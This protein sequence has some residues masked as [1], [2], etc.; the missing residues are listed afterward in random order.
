MRSKWNAAGSRLVW[1]TFVIFLFIAISAGAMPLGTDG[2]SVDTSASKALLSGGSSDRDT[3]NNVAFKAAVMPDLT[4]GTFYATA[5]GPTT[6][7][8]TARIANAGTIPSEICD[9]A[10][11]IG[12]PTGSVLD[13]QTV[14]SLS[15]GGSHDLLFHWDT[16][17]GTYADA[18]EKAYVMVDVD[19]DVKESNES[20]NSTF[21]LAQVG[22]EGTATPSPTPTQTFTVT[23]TPTPTVPPTPYFITNMESVPVFENDSAHMHFWLSGEPQADV[24]VAVEKLSGDENLVLTEGAAITIPK[25]EWATQRRVSIQAQDD[26]DETEGTATFQIREDTSTNGLDA[27]QFTAR[28][29]DD[30]GLF[31]VSGTIAASTTWSD[32]TRFYYIYPSTVIVPTGVTLTIA[33]G[34]KVRNYAS[35]RAS[36][37]VEGALQAT[38]ASF[39]VTTT[40]HD[41]TYRRNAIT[42]K[43]GGQVTLQGCDFYTREMGWR[44][45]H[46]HMTYSAAA[47]E[48]EEGGQATIGGCQFESTNTYYFYRTPFGVMASAG[49]TVTIGEYGGSPTTFQGYQGGIGWSGG[50]NAPQIA[51][52]CTSTDDYADM[53]VWGEVSQNATLP[54]FD[55][56]MEGDLTVKT[57]AELALPAGAKLYT[58]FTAD[59]DGVQLVIE[60]GAGLTANGATFESWED[61]LVAG[62]FEA[63]DSSFKFRMYAH[64]D[65]YRDNGMNFQDGSTGVFRRCEFLGQ[66]HSWKYAHRSYADWSAILTAEGSTQLT[67]E[68][69][70]FDSEGISAHPEYR[71][72]FAIKV[73]GP[74]SV[75]VADDTSGGTPI[76]TSVTRYQYGFGWE[77]CDGTLDVADTTLFIDVNFYEGTFPGGDMTRNMTLPPINFAF[78]GAGALKPGYTLTVPEGGG[79]TLP[80][81]TYTLTV[82]SGATLDLTRAEVL[83]RL[84][85]EVS[86]IIEAAS[87]TFEIYSYYYYYRGGVNLQSGAQGTFL[88]CSFFTSETRWVGD[89]GRWAAAIRANDGSQLTVDDCF[90]TNSPILTQYDGY[91]QTRHA[92][93]SY[94]TQPVQITDS[95]F[96]DGYQAVHMNAIP[97]S[98][99]IEGNDFHNNSAYAL[100]NEAAETILASGNWWGDASG[101]SHWS[102]PLGRGDPI[103]NLIAYS[104]MLLSDPYPYVQFLDPASGQESDNLTSAANQSNVE[105]VGFRVQPLQTT[106]NQV[107]FRLKER[108]GMTDWSKLSNFRLAFDANGNGKI[109]TNETT[110]FGGTAESSADRSDLLVKFKEPFTTTS[111]SSAGYILL[112]DLTGIAA[113]D[114]FTAMLQY[115]LCRTTPGVGLESLAGDARHRSGDY[116][117][118]AA[119]E[120]GQ[121]PDNLNIDSTQSSVELFGFQIDGDGEQVDQLT[122]SLSAIEGVVTRNFTSA[123]LVHDYNGN[124]LAESYEEKVGGD[125]TIAI[126]GSSGTILFNSPF[127]IG[128]HYILVA[129]FSDL[130]GGNRFTVGLSPANISIHSGAEVDGSVPTATHVVEEP[131]TLTMSPVWKRPADLGSSETLAQFELMGIQLQPSGREVNGLNLDLYNLLG[132]ETGDISNA[133]VYWD[134]DKSG[135][136]NTGD[137]VLIA[138]G[139]VS[140]ND[141]TGTIQFG[142]SFNIPGDLIV[143]ADFNNLESGDELTLELPAENVGIPSGYIITG[144]IPPLRYV[145]N[146]GLEDG[147]ANKTKWTLTYRSPGGTLVSGRYNHAGDKVILGYDTGSAWIYDSLSNTPQLMLKDH[148]DKVRYAGFSSDDSAAVT[149]SRDGAVYIGIWTPRHCE[150]Q[151]SATCWW[152]TPFP[153]RIPAN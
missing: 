78:L 56:R 97:S 51:S 152:S 18:Y 20:N 13:I 71:P 128:S 43:E 58:P 133:K 40:C 116:L 150:M 84:P 28:E 135:A 11:Y 131:Y 67:V 76:P 59:W 53:Y 129:D 72:T 39:W 125:P 110:T 46:N 80:S 38:N 153:R 19:D 41:S 29:L 27:K 140:I 9:V 86:G 70:S 30:D 145:V 144:S 68:G 146:S 24:V 3:S 102:N 69:C 106:L 117:F 139:S 8:L 134:K 118:L 91:Q 5:V 112:A 123:Q 100:Y 107:G 32:T 16:S 136:V 10:V 34:V 7:L 2:S 149:V 12:S 22:Q 98:Y 66:E 99:E 77:F 138:A 61:A 147:S 57:G 141:T 4:L 83:I 75:T 48:V 151:C 23:P 52:S 62:T 101:P 113:G 124:G 81:D 109:D 25:G 17:L 92:I 132:I 44:W 26:V 142:S 89:A 36:F 137:E 50:D 63:N 64:N 104:G 55:I 14:D 65:T 114:G 1:S 94:T 79:L 47:V 74:S 148:Y 111:S 108:A 6:Q 54:A 49:S 31:Y 105:L 96:S 95:R 33:P 21:L 60:S 42:V 87:T 127:T 90:F 88:G 122:F 37:Q 115:G 130:N 120:T 103:S 121:E 15:S 143:V 35:D 126:N 93:R 85:L 119:P 82:D 73:V 45:G